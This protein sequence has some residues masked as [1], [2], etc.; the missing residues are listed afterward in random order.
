MRL[1]HLEWTVRSAP[2]T[3]QF[4]CDVLGFAHEADQGPFQWVKHGSFELLLREGEPNPGSGCLV[5]Y[6]DALERDVARLHAAR[7]ATEKRGHCF[8]F[9]TPD[10][11]ELQLVNPNDDHSE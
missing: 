9:F 3:A 1:G 8:H 7:V 4:F 10:G 11:H 6:S 5:L 2:D